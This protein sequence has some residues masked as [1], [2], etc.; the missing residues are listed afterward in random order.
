MDQLLPP[1]APD[2]VLGMTAASWPGR[3]KLTVPVGVVDKP[4]EQAR[5]LYMADLSGVGGHVGIAGGTQSGKST[6]LRA[7]IAGLALTHTPAEVQIYCLDFGG[8]TL[9]T[10][11]E[12]PHVG[13]VAGRMDGERV[14]R[15]VAEVQGVLTTRERLFNKYGVESMSEYR[16]MRRDGRITE[17]PF[18]D[19]FLVVDGWATVRADFEEHDEPIRQIAA[20]GLTY[21]IHVV[22]TT[23]RWSDIHSALRDQLGTRLELRLGDSIDSVIDMRAA[24]GVP[25]QPGRG[26]TPEKLHFLGAVP[27]IDGRQR[28]DDLAQA[29]RALAESVA[30]SWNG[31]EAP[32]VRMLPAVLPAAELPAPEGRL[33]VPLGLG[34]SDLQ[35]VWHDFSRQPHLTVLGDTSSGKTAVLRLIAD[36]VTK[37]YAPAEAQMILVDSRRMLLEAVPD[38]Y[39]R[40][41]AFSGSAAGEL[42]SPIAAELRERL[43]GPDI[44]PQQLQRRD[45]WSGPEIFILVDDYDLLA[46]AMGG[47]LDSLLDLLPQAADIGLH[48]VLARSAAGSSRLSMDSVVRR[49]QESNTP[50]LAL[51]CPPTE[52][53]LLNGMRPRTLPPG[54][55]YMVTRRSATLLQTAWLE[56][57]GTA[58][59]S[60]R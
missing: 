4:F 37:N 16:A 8:G 51:S 18:G 36:A 2:P 28:T 32:P 53:P 42:I 6:L 43:P 14:S 60:A 20:R 33:R 38:E 59:G 25:K 10:L 27:R 1:L 7:L 12:L 9:Q 31:P 5:D 26:L 19:V 56:P 3:G 30:D 45:W 29:A 24:A 54:R 55:A 41:F 49:M 52:M 13:G 21:G 17:D 48:V 39:R 50:D 57:A 15:T 58:V 47:P 34:E 23:S 44:S 35:P 22:L 40:G 11:N 46:G